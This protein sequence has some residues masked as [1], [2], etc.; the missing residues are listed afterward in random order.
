M[1]NLVKRQQ[2]L[3]GKI[4]QLSGIGKLGA[5]PLMSYT[6]S[7]ILG[8]HDSGHFYYHGWVTGI[9]AGLRLNIYKYVFI[10]TDLQGAYANYTHTEMGADH[11][12]RSTQHFYSLQYMWSGGLNFPLGR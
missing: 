12:G 4:F 11:Q 9:S 3:R 10:Q 6:I 5:G 7:T 1:V 2:I 8:S